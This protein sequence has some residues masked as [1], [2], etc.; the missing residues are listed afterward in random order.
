MKAKAFTDFLEKKK[1]SPRTISNYTGFV[2]QFEA[3]LRKHKMGKK[4]D[5]TVKKDLKDFENW[6]DRRNLK[7]NQYLWGIKEYFD[8]L[9]KSNLRLEIDAM[10][11]RRYLSRFKLKDFFGVKPT[12]I[13]QLKKAGITTAEDMLYA[14]VTKQKRVGISRHTGIPLEDVET[15]VKL[16][17]QARIGGH[18]KVR[19]RLYHDA[20]FDTI[21]KMAAC[22]AAALRSALVSFI[23]KTGFSGIPPT[24][25][26]A[27]HTV[28]MA[29]YLKR[30]VEY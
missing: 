9:G 22:D 11:G 19:A 29:R 10:L 13:N 4:I 3:F 1:K 28:E 14:G 7:T 8:Y 12:H 25:G 2:R 26:E 18:K 30:L 17:D 23:Q 15:L 5:V 16:S 20:G 6:A 27:R 24:P 21:D